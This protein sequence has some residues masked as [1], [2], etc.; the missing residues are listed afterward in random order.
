MLAATE[1]ACGKSLEGGELPAIVAPVVGSAELPGGG[2]MRGRVD[3]FLAA[4]GLVAEDA[5]FSD[6]YDRS[7]TVPELAR[8]WTCDPLTCVVTFEGPIDVLS[9]DETIPRGFGGSAPAVVAG[10]RSKA[11]CKSVNMA[12]GSAICVPTGDLACGLL[13]SCGPGIE[14]ARGAVVLA[15]A[16]AACVE[17]PEMLVRYFHDRKKPPSPLGLF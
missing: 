13:V 1:L 16:L 9:A 10:V 8:L 7:S 17:L 2:D 5:S 3:E 15:Q 12:G 4:A 11:L 6:V 14:A